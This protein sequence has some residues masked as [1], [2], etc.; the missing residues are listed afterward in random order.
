M[1]AL[2]RF[3]QAVRHAL[4]KE[5][6]TI[7][8]DPLTLLVDERR[9]FVDL[10]AERLLGAERGMHKI[11]VEI[12]TFAGRSEVNELRDAFGQFV[13]YREL[14]AELEPEREMYIAV[15]ESTAEGIF[16]ERI[17]QILRRRLE[18]SFLTYDAENE[19]ILR[20]M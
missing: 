16:E 18:V 10:G 2:D 17:G 3:H 15:P 7:T 19:V 14:L 13:T 20:W 1:P 11:A 8:H 9:V 6:W 5:G 12:K 4:E